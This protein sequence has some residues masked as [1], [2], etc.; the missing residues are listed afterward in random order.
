MGLK[1]LG[2]GLVVCVCVWG[3]MVGGTVKTMK[4]GQVGTDVT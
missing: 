1:P 4:S 3:I 2:N